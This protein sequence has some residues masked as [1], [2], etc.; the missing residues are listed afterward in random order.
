MGLV[1]FAPGMALVIIDGLL[2]AGL[3]L[4]AIA[5]MRAVSGPA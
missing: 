1:V 3:A 4:I 2:W 5:V